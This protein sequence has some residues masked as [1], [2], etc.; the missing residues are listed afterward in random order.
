M[1]TTSF[2]QEYSGWGPGL[3]ADA[4]AA[5]GGEFA[6]E[7]LDAEQAA[8]LTPEQFFRRYVAAR[9]PVVLGAQLP[10]DRAA[11]AW[12]GLD[13]WTDAYLA[14]SA[15]AGQTVQV[16]TREDGE[17]GRFGLGREVSMPFGELLEQ[18]GAG[19][20]HLYLTTQDQG[21]DGDEGRARVMSAP[22]AQLRAD[23]PL[24]PALAGRLLPANVN[25]WM[26]NNRSGSSSGLHHDF[27]DNLYL[28]LR[29]RKRF[30]LFAP[31]CAGAMAVRGE[32]VRVH[33]NGRVNY[34]GGETAAD[35]AEHGAAAALRGA[36]AAQ[37]AL[38][39]AE[40]E[41]E[42]AGAAAAAGA[43]G[44]AARVAEAE[45]ALEQ[46]LDDMLGAECGDEEDDEDDE[47]D[48]EEVEEDENDGEGGGRGKKRAR[49]LGGGFWER[50]GYD[51]ASER[52]GFGD[53]DED[54]EEDGDAPGGGGKR[55][56]KA[57][58]A[59]KAPAHPSN[60]SAVDMSAPA[61]EIAKQFP[62]FGRA[63][64]L[65]CEVGAGE[66][67]YLPCGWFHEV[68]SFA[69][70][71]DGSGAP[72]AAGGGEGAAAPAPGLGAGHCALNY[73]FHPPDT[74]DFERPY[75]SS[76]WQDDWEARGGD[77]AVV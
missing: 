9:R 37:E 62:E 42:A 10:A 5:A 28:V 51:D 57:A 7:R 15:A 52:G 22:V 2:S 61:A 67:L 70:G 32:L 64:M 26:G 16:E 69:A 4:A 31:S 19:A 20:T 11:G 63:P 59:A 44:A 1:T 35:G 25:M 23:F 53:A 43:A 6:I 66:T 72:T 14:A 30:R 54:E 40:E 24:R 75:S 50:E 8:A 65:S 21:E 47:D 45:E 56:G 48:E 68:T 34:A 27:H 41:V 55:K 58:A 39:A 77:G 18:L 12:R 33:A 74:A 3:G 36:L 73:W 46:A 49:K 13:R 76:F 60:F 71:V 29:G 38:A 17:R